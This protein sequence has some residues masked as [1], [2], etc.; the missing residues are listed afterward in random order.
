MQKS[1]PIAAMPAPFG[2]DPNSPLYAA[3]ASGAGSDPAI[4]ELNRDPPPPNDSAFR[5]G[6]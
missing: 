2:L 4:A 6:S 1:L 5:Y 3:E